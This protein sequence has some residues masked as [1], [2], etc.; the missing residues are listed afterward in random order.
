MEF[1][2]RKVCAAILGIC[3]IGCLIG[4]GGSNSSTS[5]TTTPPTQITLTVTGSAPTAAGSQVDSGSW[6]ALTITGSTATFS[7]PQPTS[8][9]AVA[10]L[11]PVSP[12]SNPNQRE[13][14]IEANVADFATP[15]IFCPPE[16]T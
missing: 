5:L 16:T 4:C 15:T 7:V 13:V 8:N 1:F 3:S 12:S 6:T 10:V 9:Y 11:C 2:V 14:V